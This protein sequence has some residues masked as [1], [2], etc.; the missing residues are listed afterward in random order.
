MDIKGRNMESIKIMNRGK[1]LQVLYRKGC[2]SRKR[3]AEILGLTSATITI[4]VKEMIEEGLIVELGEAT[5]NKR[6]GRKE[7]N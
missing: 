6:V 3:L 7:I 5:D 2:M 1:I 4:N